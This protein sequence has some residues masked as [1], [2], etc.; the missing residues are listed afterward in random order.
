MRP[1]TPCPAPL[2]VSSLAP[3]CFPSREQPAR[4]VPAPAWASAHAPWAPAPAPRSDLNAP[5]TLVVG[6]PDPALPRTAPGQHDSASQHLACRS[7]LTPLCSAFDFKASPAAPNSA[8]RPS[9][10]LRQAPGCPAPF[11]RL[12]PLYAPRPPLTGSAPGRVKKTTFASNTLN[13]PLSMPARGP[14]LPIP[15]NFVISSI[16]AGTAA[17]RPA[18][19]TQRLQGPHPPPRASKPAFCRYRPSK[20]T[21]RVNPSRQPRP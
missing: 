15:S 6:R 18:H 19:S 4:P 21:R 7:R 10:P 9:N 8:G 5:L 16:A 3:A 20:S 17:K 13:G 2:P 1:R 12:W 11:L 14:R